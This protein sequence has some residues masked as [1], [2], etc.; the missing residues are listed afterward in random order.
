MDCLIYVCS[1]SFLTQSSIE[2]CSS[3]SLYTGRLNTC[4]TFLFIEVKINQH[5]LPVLQE[6]KTKHAFFTVWFPFD[7]LVKT[8]KKMWHSIKPESS[9]A[10]LSPNMLWQQQ[11][12]KEFPVVYV[13][14]YSVHF[15]YEVNPSYPSSGAVVLIK[16]F[17]MIILT[18]IPYHMLEITVPIHDQGKQ[19]LIKEYSK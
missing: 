8:R 15:S 6:L 19:K 18:Y 12:A 11:E 17:D 2:F 9:N 7:I 1:A 13:E 4:Y 10:K 3:A 5:Q 16:Y 14:E